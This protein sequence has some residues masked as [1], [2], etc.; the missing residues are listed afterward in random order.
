MASPSKRQRLLV[1][2][3]I[4]LSTQPE[5]MM[6]PA[7]A[8]HAD[9]DDVI[10]DFSDLSQQCGD[11]N[12]YVGDDGTGERSQVY[13][14]S[15]GIEDATDESSD[16]SHQ[17]AAV[18]V[19]PDERTGDIKGPA[20]FRDSWS[21]RPLQTCPPSLAT[22]ATALPYAAG[23]DDADSG[24]AALCISSSED[25]DIAGKNVVGAGSGVDKCIDEGCVP[26]SL[27]CSVILVCKHACNY[28]VL[29][30]MCSLKLRLRR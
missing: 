13:G 17:C 16:Q 26:G 12:A 5:T 4:D 10:E 19:P 1:D 20:V 8:T 27:Q 9:S 22:V 25:D 3:F 21:A 14:P 23:A 30:L 6:D 28:H 15:G 29:L 2:S 11:A 24:G 7:A 18:V